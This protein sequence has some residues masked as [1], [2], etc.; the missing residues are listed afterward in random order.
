[1]PLEQ[2]NRRIEEL[3]RQW[4]SLQPLEREDYERLWK[5]IRLEW[6]YNSNRMEGNTLTYS[7]TELLIFNDQDAGDHPERDYQEMK[8]HDLA[9]E[10]VREFAEDKERHLTE[11]DIRS[12]N[13]L[14]LKK[15]FWKEAETPDGQFTRKQIFPGEYKTQPNH[16]RTATGEI[17]KFAIP[18]E[19]PAKMQELVEWFTENI[20]SPPASIAS[21]LEQ[22][23]HRFILIHP[24]DD[25]NG[26]I[27]R[28]LLNYA[29]I[30]LGYP[31]FVI[32][33]KDKKTYFSALQKA[34]AG[35]IDALAVYLGRTLISWLEI[36]IKAAEGKDISEPEDI[37]KEVDIFIRGKK[38]EGLKEVKPLSEQIKKEL[39]EQ[40]LMPLFETFE[41]WFREFNCLFNSN[42]ILLQGS[43]EILDHLF[44]FMILDEQV[45]VFSKE[46][47]GNE[48]YLVISYKTYKGEKPFDMSASISV[49]LHEF[50][51]GVRMQTVVD[52]SPD[53][54]VVMREKTYSHAWT[55]SEIKKFVAEGKK[56][57]FEKLQQ[58]EKET[59]G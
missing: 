55:D 3:Y 5:K 34:D 17:F 58:K 7:E 1:M 26:R 43:R 39:C 27:V 41:S 44:L 13:L 54:R 56:L 36:G 10:K 59:A 33:D 50:K 9:V 8:A 22:L 49:A 53:S 37:N 52:G 47:A 32:K 15:P 31:P 21:F 30:R 16:V 45:E 28:L 11:A 42:E 6:N 18:E 51:Y 4:L 29:L 38:A 35:N 19:V 46:E 24:F 48:V 14:I 25:G 20:E 12:L 57:F 2:V 23:H 40:L